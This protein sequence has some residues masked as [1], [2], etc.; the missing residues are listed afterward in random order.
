MSR[1]RIFEQLARVVRIGLFCERHDISTDEGIERWTAKSAAVQKAR[2]SRREFLGSAGKL[3]A[4]VSAAAASPLRRAL[5][6]KH[7]KDDVAIVGRSI[8]GLHC[9]DTLRLGGVNATIYEARDRLGGR[10][11]SMGGTFPGPVIFPGQ[12]VERGGEFIDTTHL[13]I[14]AYAQEFKLPLEDVK[15]DWLP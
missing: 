2:R 3:A 1:N 5:A 8:A 7:A 15:K 10:M 13:T 9:A 6:G 14:K 11:W 12:V 4:A